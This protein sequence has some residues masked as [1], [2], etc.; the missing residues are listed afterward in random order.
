HRLGE[1][2]LPAQAVVDGQ[3]LR[4][5][6]SIL[7]IEEPTLL[8]LGSVEG[9][10]RIDVAVH[11]AHISEEQ[12][13]EIQTART[14]VGRELLAEVQLTRTVRV[15]GEAEVLRIANIS[16]ELHLV[17]ANDLRPVVDELVLLLALGERTVTTRHV[18][19]F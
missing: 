4:S 9:S 12:A 6:P 3:L 17:V 19:A 14:C 2:V 1:V 7:A 5:P 11:E 15:T 18:Q 16:A 10:R 8:T 13:C